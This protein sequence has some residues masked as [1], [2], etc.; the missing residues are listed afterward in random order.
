MLY[1][2]SFWIHS[3][4]QS[5]SI[6]TKTNIVYELSIMLYSLNFTVIKGSWINTKRKKHGDEI[7][8]V[9]SFQLLP[10]YYS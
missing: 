6:L 8:Y 1:K 3:Y 5:L 4:K 7:N 2:P 9:S 10:S